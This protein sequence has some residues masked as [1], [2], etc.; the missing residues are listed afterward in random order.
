MDV[1]DRRQ[2]RVAGVGRR[3]DPGL[4]RAAGARAPRSAHDRLRVAS[5]PGGA[6]S[7]RTRGS[8]RGR[9]VA[10]PA[11]ASSAPSRGC[12]RVPS[13][14]SSR[15]RADRATASAWVDDVAVDAGAD[16]AGRSAG[17]GIERERAG[18]ERPRSVTVATI[19]PRVEPD[20][21]GAASTI[22]PVEVRVGPV[23]DRA[24]EVR[25]RAPTARADPS[26]GPTSRPGLTSSSGSGSRIADRGDPAAVRRARGVARRAARARGPRVARRAAASSTSTAQIVVRGRRSASGPRSAVNATVRPSGRQAMSGDAPVARGDLARR[27]RRAPSVDDEQVRPAV[28]VARPRPSASPS[29]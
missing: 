24:V 6:R 5:L 16:G 12:R 4:D 22:Q 29:G 18:C 14:R 27:R 13:Q 15:R 9:A 19:G 28:E 3:R 17:R 10:R 7:R 26:A 25:R 23:A 11:R 2:R 20:G 21:P 8:P 1:D